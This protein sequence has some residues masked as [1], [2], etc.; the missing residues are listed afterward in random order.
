MFPSETFEM[1]C[2]DWNY[3]LHFNFCSAW[4]SFF[5][6]QLLVLFFNKNPSRNWK[7]SNA[8]LHP[9]ILFMHDV[10]VRHEKKKGREFPSF[11]TEKLQD[12]DC[13]WTIWLRTKNSIFF[14][15]SR[16]EKEEDTGKEEKLKGNE[17]KREGHM[18]LL[19]WVNLLPSALIF[20]SSL[21][22]NVR[23]SL[24]SYLTDFI[25]PRFF[26]FSVSFISFSLFLFLE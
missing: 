16:Q 19:L 23:R 1:K 20:H 5:F 10:G 21:E 25:L 6:A 2:K 13:E 11:V 26:I 9:L 24:S 15:L 22:L 3:N 17:E 8:S 14:W 4:I 7:K 18:I 12:E